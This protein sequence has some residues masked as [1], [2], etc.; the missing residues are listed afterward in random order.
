MQEV[1]YK[2]WNLVILVKDNKILLINRNKG[3]F[4]SLVPP[5]GKVEF[6]ET[7]VE[8]AKREVFEETGLTLNKV[9]LEGL[10]GFINELKGEQYVYIDYYSDDFT[11]DIIK[12]GAEGECRWYPLSEFE[13]LNIQP[14]IKTR[15]RQILNNNFYELQILWDEKTNAPSGEKLVTNNKM[16]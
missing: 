3:D 2:F 1:S 7:F 12:D 14:D 8:S 16:K 13:S 11:G 4:I 6:P 9:Q 5:G 10:S 15:I